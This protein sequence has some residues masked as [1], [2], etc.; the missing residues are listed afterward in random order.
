M[1]LEAD[2]VVYNQFKGAVQVVGEVTPLH[3][4]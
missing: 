2:Y 1:L 3:V 4:D